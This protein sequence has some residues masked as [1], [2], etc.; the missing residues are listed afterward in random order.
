M[1]KLGLEFHGVLSPLF[2]H[3]ND[4]EPRLAGQKLEAPG[5]C[6]VCILE[7]APVGKAS[8]T[9][10]SHTWAGFSKTMQHQVQAKTLPLH[11]HF[12]QQTCTIMKTTAVGRAVGMS[13]KLRPFRYP[14]EK[15]TN[16]SEP[17]AQQHQLHH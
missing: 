4:G 9:A 16:H 17:Q 2:Q 13:R 11:A 1:E 14:K 8:L 7:A 10:S 6:T 3:P 12:A 5:F 15:A